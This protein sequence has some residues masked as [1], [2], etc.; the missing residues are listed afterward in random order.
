MENVWREAPAMLQAIKQNGFLLAPR[1]VT[2]PGAAASHQ[3][4]GDTC[5]SHAHRLFFVWLNNSGIFHLHLPLNVIK[6]GCNYIL[7]RT[8]Q[9]TFQ[10][11][12]GNL[13]L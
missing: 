6:L 11:L 12:I 8:F 13:H 7:R 5:C 3:I 4:D 2:L 9:H 1:L 10:A